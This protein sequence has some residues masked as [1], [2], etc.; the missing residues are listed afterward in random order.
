MHYICCTGSIHLAESQHPIENNV[1]DNEV[2]LVEYTPLIVA[3][4]M[5]LRPYEGF[6]TRMKSSLIYEL[7]YGE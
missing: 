5:P 6:Y 2:W 3:Q 1:L 4:K 7:Y